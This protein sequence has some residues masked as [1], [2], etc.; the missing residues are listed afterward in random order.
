MNTLLAQIATPTPIMP[1]IIFWI[2][3]ILWAI[4]T[5]GWHENPKWVT[6]SNVL[7]IVLFGILGYYVMRF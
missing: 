2:L 1:K 5:F 4:G 7:L 6:G 3:L